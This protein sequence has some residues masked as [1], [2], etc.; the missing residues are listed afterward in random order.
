MKDCRMTAGQQRLK[1]NLWHSIGCYG[2][3]IFPGRRR[4]P[5]GPLDGL[6]AFLANFAPL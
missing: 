4:D 2:I 3:C 6:L 5:R 1:S